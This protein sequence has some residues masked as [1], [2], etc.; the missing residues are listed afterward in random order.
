MKESV[1]VPRLRKNAI[2]TEMFGGKFGIS[3]KILQV[4]DV[5]NL[6]IERTR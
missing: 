3:G 6:K 1:F 5:T 2:R 4:D